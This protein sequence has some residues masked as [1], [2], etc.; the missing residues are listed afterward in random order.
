MLRKYHKSLVMCQYLLKYNLKV[1][2]PLNIFFFPLSKS[3]SI[4][5]H[6]ILQAHLPERRVLILSRVLAALCQNLQ[7]CTKVSIKNILYEYLIDIHIVSTS[8]YGYICIHK[9]LFK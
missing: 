9:L 6:T 2:G 3:H 5:R 8:S 4:L 7:N 1:N